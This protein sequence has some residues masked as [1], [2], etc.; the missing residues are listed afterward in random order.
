MDYFQ[1]IES[2]NPI[3]F[4]TGK[5][6]PGNSKAAPIEMHVKG[7]KIPGWALDEY[8]LCAVLPMSPVKTEEPVEELKLV[9]MGGARLRV[10]A[11]PVVE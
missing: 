6:R 5:D 3:L 4:A 11:F 10:S 9:P 7:R 2:R 8:G 1:W